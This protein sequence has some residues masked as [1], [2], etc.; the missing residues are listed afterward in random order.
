MATFEGRITYGI[1]FLLSSHPSPNL[2]EFP[3]ARVS[4]HKMDRYMNTPAIQKVKVVQ[5]WEW[6]MCQSTPAFLEA[7]LQYKTLHIAWPFQICWDLVMGLQHMEKV[8][9]PTITPFFKKCTMIAVCF[10]FKPSL[11]FLQPF[12]LQNYSQECNDWHIPHCRR[13]A[14]SWITCRELNSFFQVRKQHQFI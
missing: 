8:R 3:Q 1:T 4:N 12:L 11:L 2:L 14:D 6:G 5:Y 7:F 9:S 10:F 13:C